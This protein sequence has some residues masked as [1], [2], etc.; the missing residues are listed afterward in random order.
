MSRSGF[1]SACVAAGAHGTA[2]QRWRVARGVML[3]GLLVGTASSVVAGTALA[4]DPPPASNPSASSGPAASSKSSD[5]PVAPPADRGSCGTGPDA[6][7]EP[8]P[9]PGPPSRTRPV[10]DPVNHSATLD[11]T[12]RQWQAPIYPPAALRDGITGLVM[13]RILVCADSSLGKVEIESSNPPGVFDAASIAA[14]KTWKFVSA[15]KNG[16]PVAGWMRF[17]IEFKL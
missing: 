5:F 9:P 2:H 7:A 8:P 16:K 6:E 14:V 10:L 3:G 11:P 12:A 4:A 15:L 17:P 13:M 1:R